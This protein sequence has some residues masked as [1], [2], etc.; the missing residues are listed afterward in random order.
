MLHNQYQSSGGEDTVIRAEVEL[1][2]HRGLDVVEVQFS[3]NVRQDSTLR[4]HLYLLKN[5]RWSEDSY[6]KIQTL[7]KRVQPD[8][9]HIHNFWMRISPAAHAACRASGIPV[10]QTLHNFRLFC[11]NSGFVR[12]HQPCMDCLGR[13][14]WRG[15]VRRCFHDSLVASAA[16]ARMIRESRKRRV[17]QECVSAYI[18]PSEKARAKLIRGGLPGDRVLVKPNFVPDPGP[19]PAR[20]SSS[21]MVLFAGRLSPEKGIGALLQAW[22][23]RRKPGRLVIAG[24]GPMKAALEFEAS[25]LQLSNVHFIGRKSSAEMN[26]FMQNCRLV[27]LPSVCEETFGMTIVEAFAAGRPAI[28]FDLGSQ[29][30][31]VRHQQTGLKVPPNDI[32]GLAAALDEA[33]GS[34]C[35]VDCTGARARS[36]YLARFTPDRNFDALMQAYQ[37]A[38]ERR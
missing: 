16:V 28:V 26:R 27:V 13:D 36:E 3:N 19:A 8:L 6:D 11:L 12:N 1:L 9:V 35:L 20:P 5:A 2:K 10:V 25:M 29:G 31:L 18:T 23:K 7:C 15:V 17:W 30:E 21:D 34:G 22:A 37:Y 33:L 38:K 14:P 24:D 32:A 4:G